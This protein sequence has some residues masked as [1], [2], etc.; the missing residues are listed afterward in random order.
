MSV[1]TY[2]PQEKEGDSEIVTLV[3]PEGWLH[4]GDF[5]TRLPHNGAFKIID[6]LK[7]VFKLSH[8]E[9]ISPEMIEV[10][11]TCRAVDFIMVYG[12]PLKSHLV[13]IAVPNE[14]KLR[15]RFAKVHKTRADVSFESL[16][17]SPEARQYILDKISARSARYHLSIYEQVKNIHLVPLFDPSLFT[18]VSIKLKRYDAIKFFEREL[19]A[20]YEAPLQSN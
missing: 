7:G 17:S 9:F 5:V 6:R 1:E 14:A 4:T 20:L 2:K 18:S 16:C 15:A 11:Y 13:A 8:G 3:D 12:N 10:C 19:A